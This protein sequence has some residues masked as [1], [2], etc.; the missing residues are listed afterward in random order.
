MG[1]QERPR[2]LRENKRHKRK[3]KKETTLNSLML[4]CGNCNKD[5][6]F[7]EDPYQTPGATKYWESTYDEPD[8][9]LLIVQRKTP[10]TNRKGKM[11]VRT[12][13][14]H[15]LVV[16]CSA[17]CGLDYGNRKKVSARDE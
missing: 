7:A 13:N 17:Q 9:S 2:L 10:S 14:E 16:F 12:T 1:Q 5:V 4:K 15:V 3:K 8:R 6:L 11:T